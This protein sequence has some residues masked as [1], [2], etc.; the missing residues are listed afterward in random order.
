VREDYPLT[1]NNIYSYH[2]F[3]AEQIIK[4]Y[5]ENYGIKSVIFRLFNIY[6]GNPLF[7]KDVISI[8][9]RAAIA[10]EPLHVIGGK[11]FRDFVHVGDVADA[12]HKACIK[13][14]AGEVINIGSG[15]KITMM[16]LANIFKNCFP[17]T[18][19][20]E[21][22]ASD[23]GTGIYADITKAKKLLGFFP[24]KPECGIADFV[25]SFKHRDA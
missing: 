24:E 2:K 23:D 4:S 12:F 18:K 8:F 13:K 20:V 5:Y 16:E 11:K 15:T 19:I 22:P 7:G 10:Q 1:P 3:V 17:D 6:G 21:K 9:C 25:L 14:I